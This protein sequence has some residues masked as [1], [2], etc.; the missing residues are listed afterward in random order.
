MKPRTKESFSD[1]Q[2][3]EFE[4]SLARKLRFHESCG[5]DLNVKICMKV[6]N[7]ALAADFLSFW[8]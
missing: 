7:G 6:A 3:L 8:H 5:C 4:A 2:L 1:L